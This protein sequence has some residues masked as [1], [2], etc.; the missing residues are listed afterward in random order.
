MKIRS[1]LLSS[2]LE[3]RNYVISN[4][5]NISQV[6]IFEDILD[7]VSFFYCFCK[8][9]TIVATKEFMCK[10]F[11]FFRKTYNDV[12]CKFL[13]PKIHNNIDFRR[14]KKISLNQSCRNIRFRSNFAC[15]A[16]TRDAR[17]QISSISCFNY[18]T[19]FTLNH[20]LI[21]MFAKGLVL[22]VLLA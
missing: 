18:F 21:P 14:K 19:S 8:D 10:S 7:C 2:E 13:W 1:I 12:S 22:F 15:C 17:N 4:S 11:S 6:I 5:Q 3:F 9:G 16:K 20:H